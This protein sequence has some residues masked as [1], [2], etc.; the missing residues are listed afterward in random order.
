M[1][2]LL[3][4]KELAELTGYHK[5][6]IVRLVRQGKLPFMRMPQGRK[7][8]FEKEAVLK[9]LRHK[10]GSDEKFDLQ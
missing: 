4:T 8:M 6:S 2:E 10:N 5:G 1:Q 3:T 9:I 7:Y